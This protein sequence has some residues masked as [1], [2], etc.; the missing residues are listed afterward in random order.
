MPRYGR[1]LGSRIRNVLGQFLVI[2]IQGGVRQDKV[3]CA[4]QYM[5]HPKTQ[6][7]KIAP[8][9]A[10]SLSGFSAVAAL[11]CFGLRL[12]NYKLDLMFPAAGPIN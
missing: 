5:L 6:R 7:F 11:T 12:R 9:C 3:A 4:S 10:G 1:K 2:G 8:F